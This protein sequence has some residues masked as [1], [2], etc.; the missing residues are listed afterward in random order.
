MD[1]MI[2]AQKQNHGARWGGNFLYGMGYSGRSG[3]CESG[4]CI[5]WRTDL[6]E[7]AV[8]RLDKM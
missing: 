2:P 1:E 3:E 6:F 7:G 8:K 4:G 5:W